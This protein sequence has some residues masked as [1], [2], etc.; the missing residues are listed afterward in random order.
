M[1]D[2][3]PPGGAWYHGVFNSSWLSGIPLDQ[4]RGKP[5][6]PHQTRKTVLNSEAASSIDSPHEGLI[7]RAVQQERLV[8]RGPGSSTVFR[9]LS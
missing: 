7:I 2:A 5:L 3:E 9:P 1:T 8:C 4:Q 6:P